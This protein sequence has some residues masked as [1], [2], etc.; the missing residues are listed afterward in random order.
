L[1]PFLFIYGEELRLIS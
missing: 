1:G